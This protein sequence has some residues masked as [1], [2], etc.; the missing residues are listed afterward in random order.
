VR[1]VIAM[2]VVVGGLGVATQRARAEGGPAGPA[3]EGSA[4]GAKPAAGG[5]K[6]RAAAPPAA[7]DL[8]RALV[9]NEDWNRVLDEYASGLAGHVANSLTA[10]GDTVPEDLEPSIRRQ[11]GQ[12][13]P[14]EHVVDVQAQALAKQLTPDELKKAASF[15][16]SPL[17]KKVTQGV[18]K[19]QSELG[20]QLQ[21]RLS[22]AVP[23]IVKR[24]APKAAAGD[25]AT[26]GAGGPGAGAQGTG[27]A[28]DPP[29]GKDGAPPPRPGA[30]EKRP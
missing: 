6:G 25:E 1:L 18:P 28:G 10:R 30:A 2:L 5:A 14:Y 17:G 15:Y 21:A 24:V 7:H 29:A 20:Q 3:A 16:G 27:S 19:A 22:T 4:A 13:L 8:A 9:S 12:E 26:S 23:Q 11:L